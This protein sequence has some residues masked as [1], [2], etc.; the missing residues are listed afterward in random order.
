MLPEHSSSQDVAQVLDAVLVS[1]AGHPVKRLVTP[2]RALRFLP[3]RIVDLPQSA[4]NLLSHTAYL[5]EDAFAA[6][7]FAPFRRFVISLEAGI[8]T[9]RPQPDA[10][11]RNLTLIIENVEK[12]P[13]RRSLAKFG[14]GLR[15]PALRRNKVHSPSQALRACLNLSLKPCCIVHLVCSHRY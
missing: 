8:S 13:G 4:H 11:Q 1:F 10:G 6:M 12:L 15:F 14:R 7:P 3:V 5:R 2:G 9:V